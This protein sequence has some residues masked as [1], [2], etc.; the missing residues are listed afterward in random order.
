MILRNSLSKVFAIVGSTTSS[1]FGL[2][3]NMVSTTTSR[4]SALYSTGADIGN[5]LPKAKNLLF[6]IPVSNNGG[7]ARIIMYVS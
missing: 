4:A 1:A 6:D 7:R 3:N 2:S 5:S